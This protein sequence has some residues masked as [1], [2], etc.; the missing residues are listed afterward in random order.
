MHRWKLHTR[1][2]HCWCLHAVQTVEASVS[3]GIYLAF[4]WEVLLNWPDMGE[5]WGGGGAGDGLTGVG[6]VFTHHVGHDMID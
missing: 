6:S 3:T 2:F 1:S 5:G 4:F